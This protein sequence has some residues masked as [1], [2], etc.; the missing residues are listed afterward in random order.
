MDAKL[1]AEFRASRTPYVRIEQL[2]T[3]QQVNALTYV[4]G[5]VHAYLNRNKGSAAAGEVLKTV[6]TQLHI[7]TGE[8]Q[9]GVQYGEQE[10]TFLYSS[11]GRYLSISDAQ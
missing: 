3:S 1:D 4:A 10:G 6:A 5:A 9:A 11:D 7:T 8:V 2:T